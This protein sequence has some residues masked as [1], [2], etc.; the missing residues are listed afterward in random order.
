MEMLAVGYD[1]AMAIPW[2]RRKRIV[3]RKA[4]LEHKRAAA[5]RQA[6]LASRVRRGR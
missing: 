5:Q 1:D 2:S 4:D 6:Q 3:E